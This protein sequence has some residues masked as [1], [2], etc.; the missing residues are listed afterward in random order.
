MSFLLN[1]FCNIMDNTYFENEYGW[2]NQLFIPIICGALGCWV[3]LLVAMVTPEGASIKK[4]KQKEILKSYSWI[5]LLVGAIAG[6]TAVNLINPQGS[7]G[8]V[9]TLSI[10]AGLSGV[11]FLLRSSLVEGVFEEKILSNFKNE[12]LDEHTSVKEELISDEDLSLDELA[13]MISKTYNISKTYVDDDEPYI[14]ED[15]PEI[16][17]D[18]DESGRN[19]D[20]SQTETNGQAD[21]SENDKN[22]H[23]ADGFDN[24]KDKG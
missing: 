5:F 17:E 19:Y 6:F 20:A 21:E 15:G 24:S 11:T 9:S 1:M 22:N 3:R 4:E 16:T 8:Q 10:I 2:I 18:I 23:K 12:T 14:E 7:F 13:K